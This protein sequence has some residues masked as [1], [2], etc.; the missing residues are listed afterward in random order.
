M[1]EEG[2][3][4]VIDEPT[5]AA[6]NSSLSHSTTSVEAATRPIPRKLPKFPVD[7]HMPMTVYWPHDDDK[8]IVRFPLS[9]R[10]SFASS[11][12]IC[13]YHMI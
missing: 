12:L 4:M 1:A 7:L 3:E 10:P 13:S 9:F 11:S 6:S 2:P 5:S 8:I